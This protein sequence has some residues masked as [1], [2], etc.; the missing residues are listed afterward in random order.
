M[1]ATH[2]YHAKPFSVHILNLHAHS[3]LTDTA[4]W[5]QNFFQRCGTNV[6]SQAHYCLISNFWK[7]PP[8][9]LT[10]AKCSR[11]TKS[12]QGTEF[13]QEM[14]WITQAPLSMVSEHHLQYREDLNCCPCSQGLHRSLPHLC[15]PC[16]LWTRCTLWNIPPSKSIGLRQDGLQIMVGGRS[17]AGNSPGHKGCAAAWGW[18]ALVMWP[19]RKMPFQ[20]KTVSDQSLTLKY[21]TSLGGTWDSGELAVFIYLIFLI[22]QENISNTLPTLQKKTKP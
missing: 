19:G 22:T 13:N 14:D 16:T 8:S 2:Q 7:I 20:L 1:P 21:I 5:V 4:S 10:V 9:R 12:H 15:R 17:C 18:L 11:G 3:H 6:A